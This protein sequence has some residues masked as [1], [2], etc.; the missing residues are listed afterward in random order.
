MS[1]T[2]VWK[3]VFKRGRSLLYAGRSSQFRVKNSCPTAEAL[4]VHRGSS[5]SGLT[6]QMGSPEPCYSVLM[7]ALYG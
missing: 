1:T 5:K 4:G 3:Q 2:H 7:Y 6:A